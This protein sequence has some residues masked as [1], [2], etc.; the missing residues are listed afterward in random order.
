MSLPL[1]AFPP[2]GSLGAN[3]YTGTQTITPAV[4]TSALVVTGFSLTGTDTHSLFDLAAT[5]NVGTTVVTLLK[6]NWTD[7]ASGALSLFSDYQMSGISRLSLGKKSVLLYNINDG[8]GNYERAVFDWTTTANVL[9][10]GTQALGTGTG[11]DVAIV[12]GVRTMT[13]N[14][15]V[16]TLA[17]PNSV[18][19]GGSGNLSLTAAG[20]LV[21]GTNSRI[22]SPANGNLLLGDNTGASFG[23]LQFGGTTS[24]FPALKRST[25]SLQAR[26]ADDSA[27]TN[28]QGKLTTDNAAVTGLVAG[29]LAALTTATLTFT[30]STGTVYRVP[31]IT[32]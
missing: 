9:T 8:A 6:L 1:V 20:V 30:D 28:I 13:F 16:G 11:R 24:S 26:L 2:L 3:T 14:A 23:I 17:I 25:T 12:A 10:I 27:F 7:T 29:A 5:T 31:A 21:F 19:I 32:P 18:T 4:N 22:N 15:S